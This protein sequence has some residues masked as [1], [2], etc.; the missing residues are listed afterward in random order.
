MRG[1]VEVA[2]GLPDLSIRQPYATRIVCK[3]R[4]RILFLPVSDIQWIGAE[5]NYV[6]IC[7]TQATHLLRRS[8]KRLE[9]TLNPEEFLRVHRSTIVNLH[10]V[11]E[12][13][14][15]PDGDWAVVMVDGQRIAMSR[16]YRARLP[17]G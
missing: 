3:S 5:A 12:V 13:R 7:T 6:R 16:T 17:M 10:Y 4:G 11:K 1:N 2:R 14:R 15:E 9:K 8:M